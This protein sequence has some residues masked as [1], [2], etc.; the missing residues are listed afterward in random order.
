MPTVK[1]KTETL[2]CKLSPYRESQTLLWL[3]LASFRS[4]FRD[5]LRQTPFLW[6]QAGGQSAILLCAHVHMDLILSNLEQNCTNSTKHPCISCQGSPTVNISPHWAPHPLSHT[7]T[8]YPESFLRNTRRKLHTTPRHSSTLQ[9]AIPQ[10]RTSLHSSG[11]G[12]FKA[13]NQ[14]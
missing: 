3:L 6:L 2:N 10:T 7:L 11:H 13:G 9:N 4:P 14:C 5:H 12:P 8:Y 1:N